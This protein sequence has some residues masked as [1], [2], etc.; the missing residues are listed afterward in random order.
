MTDVDGNEYRKRVQ[1]AID[2]IETNIRN[3]LPL[4]DVSA[5]ANASL[6]HFHR[7]FRALVG[8]S[9]K[10][11]IRHRRLDRAARD[12]VTTRKPIIE[13]ALDYRYSAPE[14]FLRAFKAVFAKT[15]SAFRK[16]GRPP[17]FHAKANLLGEEARETKGVVM[18]PIFVERKALTLFGE[19]I[20]TK[21]A[22][23]KKEVAGLWMK[24]RASQRIGELARH[25]G[26]DSVY[27]VCFGA[28]EGCGTS[29]SEDSEVFP[30][31][32]GWEAGEG[33]QPPQGLV[34]MTIPGGKFAVFT[35]R[36][37]GKDIEN[38]MN[39]IYGSWLPASGRTLS[40]SPVLEKYGPEWKG[41]RGAME[42]WLPVK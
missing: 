9:L 3:E 14:S 28:C 23:C 27:G 39:S 40:D 38:V 4:R 26:A 11:Y 17:N 8:E 30:Y 37:G 42:I 36:G 16:E 7:L 10:E 24:E 32:I 35:V 2:F 20:H 21:H 25:A 31:L 13:I 12:L 6:Y 18:E 19:L 41:D 5:Q 34:E 29:H 15:P 1:S 22:A 33:A